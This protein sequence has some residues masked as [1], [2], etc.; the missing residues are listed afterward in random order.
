MSWSVVNFAFWWHSLLLKEKFY[1]T[2]IGTTDDVS[3]RADRSSKRESKRKLEDMLSNID[4]YSIETS[5]SKSTQSD[6]IA[7]LKVE[8]SR[9][10][11]ERDELLQRV[12]DLDSLNK[13][14][15]KKIRDLE[16]TINCLQME[17]EKNDSHK[18]IVENHIKLHEKIEELFKHLFSKIQI[19]VIINKRS[20][21]VWTQEDI[22]EALTLRSLSSRI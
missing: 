12:S 18:H 20:P 7:E 10:S 13:E 2:G 9:I 6:E 16:N 4:N 5:A 14:K 21:K 22:S 19:S 15:D 17:K 3:E 11:K 8:N 1:F